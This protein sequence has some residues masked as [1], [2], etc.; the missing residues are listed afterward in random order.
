MAEIITLSQNIFSQRAQESINKQPLRRTVNLA[1]LEI[2]DDEHIGFKGVSVKITKTAFQD[3]MR[4]LKIPT[5]FIQRFG[6]IMA[7]KPEAKRSFIN[8]IKNILGTRGSGGKNVTLVL[9]QES[10]EVI[11]VHKTERNLISNANFMEVVTQCIDSNQLDVVDFSINPDGNTVINALNTKQQFGIGNP[12]DNPLYK[13]EFF[14]GGVSFANDPKNGFVIS[15]YINRLVC[16]NGSVHRGFQETYKLTSTDSDTMKK[17]FSDLS[18]L[19]KK[20]FKP[21]TFIA[22]VEESMNLKASLSELYSVKKAIKAVAKDIKPEEMERWVPIKYNDAAYNRIGIETHLLRAGQLKNAK[23]S[24][25]V[26]ELINGLTAFA[27]HHNGFDISDY[28]RRGLQI[29]AGRLLTDEHDMSNFIR[30]P[31]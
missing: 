12:N 19:A 7:E 31:W 2:I 25:S 24:I 27:T 16:A 18:V 20:G 21:E 15:P 1:E 9:S 26:W 17:F 28:D 8:S 14:H 10:R 3:L 22:R 29:Q 13:D 23:S 6:E 5:A 11:A 4:I 30:N